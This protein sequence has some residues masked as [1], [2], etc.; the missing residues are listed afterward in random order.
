MHEVISTMRSYKTA[1]CPNAY[2]GPFKRFRTISVK[3]SFCGFD[4]NL[5]QPR[6]GTAL[7]I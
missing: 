6:N 2:H 7:F 5:F 4:E 1:K 3:W